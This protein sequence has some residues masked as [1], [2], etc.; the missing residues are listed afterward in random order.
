MGSSQQILSS[1][2]SSTPKQVLFEAVAGGVEVSWVVPS[3]VTSICAVTIGAGEG[4]SSGEGTS[5]G[6][7]ADLVYSNG[8]TVTP[9]ETL[10]IRVGDAV[11]GSGTTQ[12][13]YIKR[14]TSIL[15]CAKGGGTSDATSQINAGIGAIGAGGSG[16]AGNSGESVGGGGGGAGGYGSSG[17]SGG[18]T[19]ASSGNNGGGGGGVRAFIGNNGGGRGGNTYPYG[20]LTSGAA[21]IYSEFEAEWDG[22]DGSIVSGKA[23]YG[24][25]AGGRPFNGSG[26]A[27]GGNGCVR[28]IWGSGRSFPSTRTLDE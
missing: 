6:S 28:I 26:D 7:G 21:G 1:I 4:S 24:G 22:G 19:S 17:G 10:T 20:Q 11:S 18:G 25:G 5:G 2:G 15:V 8:I 9:G 3:D 12:S 14:G 16:G 27:A 13:S 23:G